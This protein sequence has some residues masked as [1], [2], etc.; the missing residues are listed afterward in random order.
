MSQTGIIVAR[1]FNE[2]VRKKSFIITT[3][4]V[5]VFMLACMVIPALILAYGGGSTK[6]IAVIDPSGVVAPALESNEEVVFVPTDR[7][8]EEAK[9]DET[10][11][12]V[13]VIGTD[14]VDS[15]NVKLYTSASS[16]M[17]L[18]EHITG[19]IE[20]AVRQQRIRREEIDN[21]DE[22]MERI[23]T[24]VSLQT[25]RTDRD[26]QVQSAGVAYGL[27]YVLAFVLYMFLLLY[28]QMVM[29]SVIE[30]KGSRVLDVVIT[31]VPPFRLMLGKI[32]GIA[33][34]AVTQIVIWCALLVVLFTTVLPAIIPAD[35]MAQAQAL[36]AGQLDPSTLGG[37][38]EMLQ[39][40]AT[41][42]DLGYMGMIMV[43]L[44]LFLIGG[45]LLYSAMFAAVG[46]S[47]DSVQ[48]ASQ[49]STVVTMPIIV[50]LF[51]MIAVMADPNS[52]AAFWFSM[53]PFTSPMVMM[54]RIPAG[55]PA[56]ES[57]LSLVIL[58][59]TTLLMIW[60]AAKIYRV[61]VFMHGKKPT[62]K[63]LA[64]WITYKG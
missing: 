62:F 1:E 37:D 48:D 34:V 59:A 30:E 8:L 45:Y 24:T 7:S 9:A 53:I 47:V 50:G 2:R 58:A 16:S 11:F 28:G 52:G 23:K 3:L 17:M 26:E 19:Q 33:T 44:V 49:L 42:T 43:Y 64:R 22:V 15:P 35:T 12:G 10:L 61:G 54:A 29:T 25:F 40:L 31:S 57:I 32:L 63:D 27:G 55:I 39:A 13:L 18:E 5:P 38:T 51:A 36:Q 41:A 4:L 60:L 14:V 56:W 21:L 20:E 46:A 6:T